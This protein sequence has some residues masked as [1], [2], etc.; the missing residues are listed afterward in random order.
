M[1]KTLIGLI[2]VPVFVALTAPAQIDLSRMAGK[3]PGAGVTP[4]QASGGLKEALGRGIA[5]AVSSTGHPGGYFDNPAIKIGMP[6]K[7]Q[8]VEQ[9][10][11]MA[12]M[13]PQVDSLVKSMNAAAE[14]AAPAAK[15]ILVKALESMTI[16]DAKGIVTGGRTSG[17][18]YFQRT[19][20]G[21]IG[22]AFRP[23]VDKAMAQVGVTQQFAALMAKA[24]AIPFMKTPSLDINQY[25][26]EKSV[27]GLFVV[28]GQ[29][30]TKIR[31]DPA[32]Q[33]TP[34]LRKV[35]GGR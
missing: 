14:Q 2:L 28:M 3:V 31:T 22:D 10:M 9:G 20:S 16:Q 29:E 33:V 5:Q 1:R 6:P 27:D 15:P 12:G 19:S 32:A 13:G 30:E 25:V 11:R 7:L 17:T 18:E 8:R 4:D 34:L 23:I 24:P 35:F 26:L 21:A